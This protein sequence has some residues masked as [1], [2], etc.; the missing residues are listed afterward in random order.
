MITRSRRLLRLVPNTG[1]ALLIVLAFVV[2]LTGLVLAYFSRTGTDRQLAQ[3]SFNDMDADLLARSALDIV[4]GDFKQEIVS[5]STNIAPGGTPF[6]SPTPATNVLPMRSGNPTF[7]L[8]E[9]PN[10]PI[11][12]LIRRS[13]RFNNPAE[14]NA[15]PSPGVPSRASA[16]NSAADISANGRSIGLAKWNS[17]YLIPRDPSA[18]GDD[19]KPINT[20]VAPDWVI[21]T[22]AGPSPFPSWNTALKD[23][24]STNTTYAVGRYA[25]AVYDEGGLLDVNVAGFP[26]PSSIPVGWAINIGRKSVLAVANLTALP[27]TPGNFMSTQAINTIVAFRNYATMGLISS[28]LS[29]TISASQAGNFTTYYLGSPTG[30]PSPSPTPWPWMLAS[31]HVGT[32][33]DFG[34]VNMV[35]TALGPTGRTDQ[36]FITRAELIKLRSSTNIASVNTLQYFGTFSRE[37]NASTWR[38][39]GTT[40]GQIEANLA[41]PPTGPGR[42]YIGALN[43]VV[44][45]QSVQEGIGL[46]WKSKGQPPDAGYGYWTY[47]GPTNPNALDHIPSFVQGAKHHFFKLL[48]YAM[49][50]ADSNSDST[51]DFKTTLSVG[52]SLIDQYD[53][54]NNFNLYTN[55]G[56]NTGSYT[57]AIK[58]NFLGY[59]FGMERNDANIANV[60]PS[61]V[62]SPVPTPSPAPTPIFLDHY[63]DIGAPVYGGRPLRGVGEFGYGIKTNLAGLPTIDFCTWPQVQNAPWGDSPVLDF[64]SYNKADPAIGGAPVRSGIVS[65]NTRQPPVLAALLNGTLLHETAPASTVTSADATSAADTIVNATATNPALSRADIVRLASGVINTSFPAYNGTRF[66]KEAREAIPRALAENVQA[67]TWGLLIDLVAQTGHY[68]PNAQGLGDFIVEG[69]KRYWLHIAIDR[70]DGTVVGQQLEEALQ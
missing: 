61:P 34:A 51:I 36:S 17:H 13:I 29:S 32:S 55:T 53:P 38:A 47:N 27:T 28:G 54:N 58:A 52:A 11:P 59:L 35:K 66:I 49:T 65:L 56:D 40:S 4:V 5:G 10:D 23:P 21:V 2:L 9:Y 20:F 64:F 60:V 62:P 12:N 50:A 43:S 6:Y 42:F 1:A 7:A 48:E 69:E 41:A 16:I 45:T 70:F 25:Y 46:K 18:T 33:Q 26:S 39:N 8:P 30:S 63:L 68:S 67:R 15:M 14:L 57:T 19:P 37:K 24:T 22:R 3:S 44:P 31:D